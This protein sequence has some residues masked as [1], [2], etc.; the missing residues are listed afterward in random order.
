MRLKN[1]GYNVECTIVIVFMVQIARTQ[2]R[3]KNVK[4]KQVDK[5]KI[6]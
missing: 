4:K 3:D 6:V 5:Q 1:G 2:F